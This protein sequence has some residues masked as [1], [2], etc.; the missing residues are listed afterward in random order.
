MMRRVRRLFPV[1]LAAFLAHF[2]AAF[3]ASFADSLRK[4]HDQHDIP[5]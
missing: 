4:K 3:I 2:A 1:L 5:Q